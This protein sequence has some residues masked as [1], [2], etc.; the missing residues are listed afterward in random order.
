M[1]HTIKNPGTVLGSGTYS[2]SGS[3]VKIKVSSNYTI[4]KQLFY[5]I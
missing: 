1:G 4:V 3:W 2:N 5:L